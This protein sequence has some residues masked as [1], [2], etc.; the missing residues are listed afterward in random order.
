VQA[1]KKEETVHR[2]LDQCMTRL[3]QRARRLILSYYSAEKAAKTESHRRLADEF[4]K[5][6]NALRIEVHRIR[7]V[8]RACLLG[9][10]HP[11]SVGLSAPALSF[12][13]EVKRQSAQ[14]GAVR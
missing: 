2:C 10:A 6:V 4:G 9:C 1:W 7:N 11:E 8:L 3:T 14:S 5:S 12:V 13:T